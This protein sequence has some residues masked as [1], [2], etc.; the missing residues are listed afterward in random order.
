MIFKKKHNFAAA[1]HAEGSLRIDL[2]QASRTD[3]P[4]QTVITEAYFEQLADPEIIS[5]NVTAKVSVSGPQAGVYRLHYLVS[6]TALTPCDRCGE[7]VSLEIDAHDERFV[8]SYDSDAEPTDE[9]PLAQRG[10]V[11]DIGHDVFEI[12]ALSRP[13]GYSHEEGLC[14][15]EAQAFIA[16]VT[17]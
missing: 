7:M 2:R 4:I 11:Y 8:T 6:G 17:D 14:S 15:D 9:A 16:G 10:E 13:L 5:A 12:I 3:E 1:M